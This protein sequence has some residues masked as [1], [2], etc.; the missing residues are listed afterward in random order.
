MWQIDLAWLPHWLKASED[1]HYLHVRCLRCDWSASFNKTVTMEAV[2]AEVSL[3]TH[4]P[5]AHVP[6]E[7]SFSAGLCGKN[8]PGTAPDLALAR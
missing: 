5:T 6:S 2:R 4:E 1:F 8:H 3:H 7:A